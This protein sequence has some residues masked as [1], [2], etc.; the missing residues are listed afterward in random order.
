MTNERGGGREYREGKI[1]HKVTANIDSWHIVV[2]KNGQG[3][4]DKK[5]KKTVITYN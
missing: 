2:G 1:M 4:K 5:D 3:K